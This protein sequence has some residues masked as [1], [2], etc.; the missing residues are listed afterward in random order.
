[1]NILVTNDDGVLAPSLLALV[2]EM[3]LIGDVSI[4]TGILL[5]VNIPFLPEDEING[6]QVTRQGMRVYRDRFDQRI[7][8]RGCPY[9]WIAGDALTGIPENGTDF[10]A[11][12]KGYVSIAPLQLELT[13]YPA[14]HSLTS[15]SKK[16]I[17]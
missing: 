16:K 3:R 14:M 4:Q 11:L 10:G 6:F 9:F 17:P 12:A 5:N 8:A 7:D 15:G 2:H 13:A 1:M